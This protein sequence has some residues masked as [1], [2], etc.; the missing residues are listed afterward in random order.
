MP[1]NN[2]FYTH[3]LEKMALLETAVAN[4]GAL[5][6]LQMTLPEI[7]PVSLIERANVVA[8][9][10][11]ILRHGQD[12]VAHRLADQIEQ[13]IQQHPNTPLLVRQPHFTN[14][15]HWFAA[16]IALASISERRLALHSCHLA[17]LNTMQWD[18]FLKIIRQLTQIDLPECRLAHLDPIRCFSF[19]AALQQNTQ[20]LNLNGINLAHPAARQTLLNLISQ[21]EPLETLDLSDTDLEKQDEQF[22]EEFTCALKTSHSLH[23]IKGLPDSTPESLTTTLEIHSQCAAHKALVQKLRMRADELREENDLPKLKEISALCD[24]QMKNLAHAKKELQIYILEYTQLFFETRKHICHI[25]RAAQV[26]N[27]NSLSHQNLWDSR[28][29]Q[30]HQA[31]SSALKGAQRCPHP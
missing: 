17:E 22:W 20:S 10:V 24:R 25:Q 1:K 4:P 5:S 8:F 26:M 29:S 21:L 6:E 16:L 18:Y 11:F 15:S 7:V 23:V 3:Y 12:Q 28:S 14:D 30:R 31:S 27:K 2:E 19:I 13:H 9:G